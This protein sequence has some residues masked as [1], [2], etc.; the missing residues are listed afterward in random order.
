MLPV[1]LR[2]GD[3]REREGKLRNEGQSGRPRAYEGM[4]MS[5]QLGTIE[6]P[7]RLP[8]L[9]RARRS[10]LDAPARRTGDLHLAP[11]LRLLID[12]A[13]AVQ[14]ERILDVGCGLQVKALRHALAR[15]ESAPSGYV[16][17]V[18]ISR[19]DAGFGRQAQAGG[20]AAGDFA[21]ADER[22]STRS[23]RHASSLLVS[24]FGV[25]FFADPTQF[26]LCPYAPGVAT[27]GA[28]H[29]RLLARAAWAIP[30]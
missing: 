30:G 11:I 9:R 21:L 16:L 2:Y 26:F 18:D 28:C 1:R 13:G 15:E 3:F 20:P 10:A 14:H 27:V 8:M 22:R 7:T 19:A 5:S 17:G 4:D 25:M 23:I 24:R 29:V 12:C 6:M